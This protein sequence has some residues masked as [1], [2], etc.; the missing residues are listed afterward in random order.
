[1]EKDKIS[2]KEIL[3][4]YLSLI[5]KYRLL[6]FFAVFLSIFGSLKQFLERFLLKLG[7][8][9]ATDYLAGKM[10][11][12]DLINIL[13]ILLIVFFVATIL[14]IFFSF[15]EIHLINKIE[16][17]AAT[18]LKR[19]YFN[20]ILFLDYEFFTKHK[21]GSLISRLT[22]GGS[23]VERVTDSLFFGF[24]PLIIQFLIA[25]LSM[26]YLGK[27]FS[28]ILI[29]F[30]FAFLGYSFI[31]QKKVN[32][33]QEEANKQEDIEKGNVADFFTNIDSIK[34]YGKEN[35]IKNKFFNLTEN[36]KKAQIKAWHMWRYVSSGQ[37]LI[38][39][40]WSLTIIYFSFRKF[41][42]GQMSVG[43]LTFVYTT[44]LMFINPL[45]DFVFNVRNFMRGLVDFEEL[46]AYGKIESKIKDKPNATNLKVKEGKI[47]FDKISFSYDKKRRI[48][49]DLYLEITAGKKVALVGHSGSGKTTLVKL[50][51]RMY[52]VQKGR[53]LID[54]QDIRDVKQ[55]SLRNEMAIIPQECVLFDDTI[56][57][58]IKFSKPN[59][60]KEEVWKAIKFAKL[61]N[62]IKNL[63]QK[64]NTIVGE[65][66]IKLSGG[67]KQRVSIARAILADKKILVL[68]EATSS[69]DSET[70]HEI[71]EE[72]KELMKGRT[73][74][75]IAHRLS[76]IMNADIIVVLKKGK[77]V[78][79][80]KHKDLIKQEGEY[81]KLWKL[82]K[83][84]YIK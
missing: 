70:E 54:N 8:D 80:G 43:D 61:D 41:L 74:I 27:T 44:F 73:T 21:T 47:I 22:R 3:K 5:K 15:I 79:I 16:A 28:F 32:F 45:F 18:G 31:L 48:F 6:I 37:I 30:T 36:T 59:A 78:Q 84:G 25:F 20:H 76:T 50:L 39:S 83:G 51:Y 34:Y 67:E 13:G 63:P 72:L 12:S 23:A 75:I 66:G 62:F 82:Q 57:N 56:F 35:W 7:I 69:L 81:S 10:F 42:N 64:E 4:D 58:N 17:E 68:D 77:I 46:F 49:E 11:F 55:E 38:L 53:I 52:D 26:L 9:K 33:Y 40:L 65:R 24:L 29:I 2:K 14:A 60:T 1:M 19:K 71:Q